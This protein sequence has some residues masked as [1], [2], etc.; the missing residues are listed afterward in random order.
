MAVM[1]DPKEEVNDQD[2]QFRSN[3]YSGGVSGGLGDDR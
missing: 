1:I 2:I 3:A